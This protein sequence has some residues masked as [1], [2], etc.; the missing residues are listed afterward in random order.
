MPT[1]VIF[2]K[3][4]A[5]ISTGA[6]RELLQAFLLMFVHVNEIIG[7]SKQIQNKNGAMELITPSY[8]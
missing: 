6:H 4:E 2:I 3:R 1:L 8:Y 5:L 7:R